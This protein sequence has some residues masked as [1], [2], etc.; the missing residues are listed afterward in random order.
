MGTTLAAPS[1]PLTLAY[2]AGLNGSVFILC[3]GYD[4]HRSASATQQSHP[5]PLSD[6]SLAVKPVI[7]WRL[8]PL[9]SIPPQKPDFAWS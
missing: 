9:L 6:G 7:T 2:S 4:H 5:K 1:S 3:D 8:L